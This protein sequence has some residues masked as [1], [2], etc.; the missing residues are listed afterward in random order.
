MKKS[1]MGL[2]GV[3]LAVG[4]A[5]TTVVPASAGQTNFGG[6]KDCG[7]PTHAFLEATT[8]GGPVNI[9][10]YGYEGKTRLQSFNS[11]NGWKRNY[12]NSPTPDARKG[13]V[14]GYSSIQS[15]GFGC[16]I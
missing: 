5:L 13:Y 1:T 14:N 7:W 6:G 12:T 10:V 2:S 9:K 4:L 16:S 8:K 15:G 3:I 11:T